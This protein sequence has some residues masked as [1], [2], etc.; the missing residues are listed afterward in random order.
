MTALLEA[1]APYR[2]AIAAALVA[3]LTT[4]ATLVDGGLTVAEI[5]TIAAAAVAAGGGVYAVPNAP[6][7]RQPRHAERTD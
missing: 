2:K 1:I 3:A 6:R 4:A 5:L 7:A